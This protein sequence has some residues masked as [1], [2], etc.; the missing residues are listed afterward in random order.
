MSAPPNA[1]G[2]NGSAKP[3]KFEPPPRLEITTSGNSPAISNCFFVSRP[4]TL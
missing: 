4:I 1:S 2:M 3:P